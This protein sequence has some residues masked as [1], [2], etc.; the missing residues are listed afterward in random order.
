MAGS[1]GN[2]LE[3]MRDIGKHYNVAGEE[4]GALRLISEAMQEDICL[5]AGRAPRR[6]HAFWI[7]KDTLCGWHRRDD[8]DYHAGS[9]RLHHVC[10]RT[11]SWSG[12][13]RSTRSPPIM[14]TH[15]Y[16]GLGTGPPMGWMVLAALA[17]GCAPR[18]GGGPVRDPAGLPPRS[19][20]PHP[21]GSLPAAQLSQRDGWP[22]THSAATPGSTTVTP[23]P[24]P[25]SAQTRDPPPGCGT[26]TTAA[27]PQDPLTGAP[28]TRTPN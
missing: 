27:P 11:P 28:R 9:G 17:C 5:S 15:T 24:E 16:D 21:L 2:P 14:L 23:R 4:P 18:T 1:D 25:R 13:R 6:A 22:V 8:V 10:G 26:T 3:R 12:R 7:S 20:S 19:A